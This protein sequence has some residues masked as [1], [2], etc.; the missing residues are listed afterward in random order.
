MP[1]PPGAALVTAYRDGYRGWSY[2]ADAASMVF[3]LPQ[4]FLPDD[5]GI[6]VTGHFLE[7]G[8]PLALTNPSS[9][10]DAFSQK[11]YAGFLLP[12]VSR[13][14]LLTADLAGLWSPLEFNLPWV[15]DFEGPFDLPIAD[16]FFLPD[17]S[18]VF[19]FR[20]ELQWGFMGGNDD[21][22]VS[23]RPG[24]ETRPLEG[25]VFSAD[26]SRALD[27]ETFLEIVEGMW[28]ANPV[29]A[30]FLSVLP[31]LFNDA[32]SVEYAGFDPE[33]APDRPADLELAPITGEK[34]DVGVFATDF[35]DDTTI[36]ALMLADVPNRALI[37][38]GVGAAA[39]TET[40]LL[41]AMSFPD[42]RHIALAMELPLPD[43]TD[44]PRTLR[45]AFRYASDPAAWPNGIALADADFGARFVD[46][47]TSYD[48]GTGFIEWEI[49]GDDPSAFFVVVAPQGWPRSDGPFMA[50][51]P[52]GA[53]SLKLP[54]ADLGY[55]PW[56]C[57]G[58]FIMAVD[59]PVDFRRG[60]DPTAFFAY[61]HQSISMWS[62]DGVENFFEVLMYYSVW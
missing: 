2:Q 58:V 9:V 56:W 5:Y 21:L 46:E 45:T 15:Y 3:R 24:A 8:E 52:G 10:V 53:R 42:A 26:L 49:A 48:D 51:L 47:K 31:K 17:M 18:L 19:E 28:G 54:V 61:D 27:M 44:Y 32:V 14:E 36:L 62:N 59:G 41:P 6:S 60:F 38:I 30:L 37:P 11:A 1:T 16:N 35:T 40:A 12:A 50:M 7:N 25:F 4:E 29:G 20:N 33:W 43:D 34:G 23:L 39:G 55:D 13:A 22:T 57:D